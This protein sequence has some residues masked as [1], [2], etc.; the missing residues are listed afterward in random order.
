MIRRYVRTVIL[1]ALALSGPAMGWNAPL[2][3]SAPTST[4]RST[5][6]IARGN[7]GTLNVVY[8]RKGGTWTIYYRQ[9]SAAGNWGP[10][11]Q[12]STAFAV[13]P[14]VAE[15]SAGRPHVI[16][17]QT[18]TGGASAH[19]A[20]GPPEQLLA[21]SISFLL[22]SYFCTFANSPAASCADSG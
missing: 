17:A 13:R 5:P 7:S 8:L 19:V 4:E 11:E 15:D 18:N 12:V 3:I 2:E 14:D 9:K 10:V 6:R 22:N 16:M 20:D 1:L 21:R